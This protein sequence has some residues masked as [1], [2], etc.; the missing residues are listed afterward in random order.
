MVVQKTTIVTNFI[1]KFKL[2]MTCNVFRGY[3]NVLLAFF[4]I[5]TTTMQ[6]GN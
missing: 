6:N 2:F 5:D 3:S 4:I 1:P